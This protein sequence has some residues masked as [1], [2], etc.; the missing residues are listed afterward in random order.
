MKNGGTEFETH[1]EIVCD[2]YRAQGLADI[3]KVAPPV[4][5]FGMDARGMARV[6]L[7]TNPFLDFV[8]T[9]TEQGG[10]AIH[11]EAKATST[12]R[13]PVGNKDG[14]DADQLANLRRW[15]KAGAAVGVLWQH[16]ETVRFVSLTMI[17]HALNVDQRKSV[18]WIDGYILPPGPGLV[19]FDFLAMLRVLFP[20]AA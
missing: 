16:A 8:G 6:A 11:L 9:W 14:V 2:A 12:P 5:V 19:S 3:E 4:K 10:R 17:E 13:L 7:L 15:Y 1:V 20:L 18:P